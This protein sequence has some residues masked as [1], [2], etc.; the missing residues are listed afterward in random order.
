MPPDAARIG[1]ALRA[2]LAQRADDASICPSE[3]ARA[4]GGAHWRALMPAVRQIA[5][6]LA[7]EG[8]VVLTQGDPVLDPEV[9]PVGAIRLRRGPRWRG[10]A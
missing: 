9:P 4:I 2:L 8:I 3:G 5:G 1:E 6:E 7:G 10:Q